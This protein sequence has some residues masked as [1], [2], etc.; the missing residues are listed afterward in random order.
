MSKETMISVTADTPR[1]DALQ[2]SLGLAGVRKMNSRAS[3]RLFALV[4]R[5]LRML[6]S[7]RHATAQRLGAEPTG[8]F[9]KAYAN[10]GHESD[11]KGGTVT[12][13]A[14][15]FRRVFGD[16]LV[17]PVVANALTIPVHPLSYGKRVSELQRDGITVVRPKGASYL[18]KPNKDGSVELLYV[19]AR[20]A[21]IR[22]DRSLL[23][24][25]E[26]MRSEVRKGYESA[27]QAILNKQRDGDI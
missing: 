12:V 26:E 20:S 5:H 15:G 2:K 21:L 22:Q 6:A 13:R 14:P 24:S 19:L 25:D 17:L 9:E 18:I 7:T 1:L 16:V 11:E 8:Y 27:I 10:T 3:S 4:R 23:P